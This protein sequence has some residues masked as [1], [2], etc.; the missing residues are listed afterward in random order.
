MNIKII[1]KAID[2][3]KSVSDLSKKVIDAGDSE[4][5]AKS[6]NELNQGVSDSY[7]AMRKIIMDSDKFS[8]DEKLERLA[9]LAA[10]EEETKKKCGE[11]IKGNREHVSNIALEITKGLL[12]CGVSFVPAIAK[13]MKASL[14]DNTQVIDSGEQLF[15]EKDNQAEN[16]KRGLFGK[17][18]K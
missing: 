2:L 4:K 8:D 14:G 12:T 3:F 16:K 15:L 6:V 17:M 10:Q 18:K 7:E 1:E 13:N 5:Y 9:K 11:A